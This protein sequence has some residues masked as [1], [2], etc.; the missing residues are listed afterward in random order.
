[1]CRAVYLRVIRNNLDP[2]LAAFD[3]PLPTA[4][5][6]KRDATN[7]P[8]QALA[9]L[10]NPM[11]IGWA[12]QWAKRAVAGG[13][14]DEGRVRQM[15]REAFGRDPQAGEMQASLAYLRQGAETAVLD[16]GSPPAITAEAWRGFAQALFNAKEFQYLR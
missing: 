15:F 10:N 7:V 11:V 16:A 8:A 9:L 2:L 14:D 3:F 5:R 1:M 13:S 6:G 4:T 12:D